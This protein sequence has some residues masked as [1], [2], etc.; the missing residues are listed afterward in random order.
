MKRF[1]LLFMVF[2]M[3]VFPAFAEK[4]TSVLTVKGTLEEMG[5]NL[6]DLTALLPPPIEVRIEN[7]T[8]MFKDD[9]Y[10]WVDAALDAADM[11][12]GTL[13]NGMWVLEIGSADPTNSSINVY[14]TGGDHWRF[15]MDG[16]LEYTKLNLEN[17]MIAY[18]E[19]KWELQPY[20]QLQTQYYT[21]TYDSQ[22]QL[23]KY[24]YRDTFSI[25]DP[26]PALTVEVF[27]DANGRLTGI[28][29]YRDSGNKMYMQGPVYTY[30][31]RANKGKGEWYNADW[32]ICEGPGN[33]KGL[34]YEEIAAVF[35][36]LYVAAEQE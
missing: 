6:E 7:G 11:T 17:M 23:T 27:Y 21:A 32:N 15:G 36:P 28:D 25:S 8:A 9:Q 4:K 16:Q 19:G 35:P 14:R 29:M 33:L 3:A 2:L 26:N 18:V 22:G 1:C 10:S 31:P 30:S 13:N 12:I 24:V 20:E 34:S 5:Y